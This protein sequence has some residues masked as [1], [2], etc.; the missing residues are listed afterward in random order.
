MIIQND[1]RGASH[2]QRR[3]RGKIVRD[4]DIKKLAP[5][6]EVLM[7]DEPMGVYYT[8]REPDGVSP[9]SQTPLSR[10]AEERGEVNWQAV[11]ENFSCVLGI[12]W[13]ARR[14][15]KAAF[16][17]RE[18]FGC[19]GG[20]FYLGFMKPYLNMHPYFI[21]SGIPG[22]LEGERYA[23]SPEA[24]REFFDLID[25]PPAPARFCVIK[26]LGLFAEGEEPD[27]V[28][29]F[30]R[31]EVLSGLFNLTT[32]V[33]GDI[34]AVRTPFG[35]GCSGLVTWPAKYREQG[36]EYALLG[37]F[38]PSCRRFLKADE[39]SFAVP[40]SLY[41]KMITL[42]GGSFLTTET[43]KTVRKK[44]ARSRKTWGEEGK[45]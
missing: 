4:D 5:L 14:K 13:R 12:V 44:I 1:T 35:P 39:L 43:W 36:K 15:R 38:D 2:H 33:T 34:D 7:A 32:F 40:L 37:A 18:R 31:P 30:G 25:P 42:W 8:D 6:L 23:D 20:A 26:P 27:T 24:A 22:F 9:K 45:S 41:R 29:F 16:F 10:E 19:P 17:D 3:K 21:S 11:M 28:V